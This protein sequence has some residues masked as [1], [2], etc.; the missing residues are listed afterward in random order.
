[1]TKRLTSEDIKRIIAEKKNEQYEQIKKD[2]ERKIFIVEHR[3]EIIKY[4][5]LAAIVLIAIPFS[6]YFIVTLLGDIFN[7]SPWSF[8]KFKEKETPI[9]EVATEEEKPPEDFKVEVIETDLVKTDKKRTY[10]VLGKIR[11]SNT[12]W[13][14]SSLKYKFILKDN[15]GNKIGEKERTSYILPQQERYLVEIGLEG[16]TE[17]SEVEL[18]VNINEV[19]KLETFKN[20]QTQFKKENVKY[21]IDNQKSRVGGELVNNSSFGFDKVDVYIIVYDADGRILGINYTNINGFLP[22]SNRYFSVFWNKILSKSES[23]VQIEIEPNVDVFEAGNFMD[24][25]GTG[26][27]LEY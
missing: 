11:N 20:P 9:V 12:E 24:I 21:Y 23:N 26:Q 22:E 5:K 15:E 7:Y 8:L 3:E 16:M 10:D 18:E 6:I 17:A 27:V 13:G 4:A 2:T 25:Y 14:V 1:M 19:Q